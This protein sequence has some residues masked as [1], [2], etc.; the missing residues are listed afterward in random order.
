VIPQLRDWHARYQEAGLTIVGVH[1]PEFFW[2]RR[3]DSVMAATRKLAVPYPV[4][5]D[6]D[7]AIW[8]RYSV[9]A[10][11]TMILVDRRGFMRYRHVGEGAYATTEAMLRRLLDEPA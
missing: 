10:W 9:S 11:P 8:E 5:L 2:E 1:T 6:N 7:F 4:V 3:H